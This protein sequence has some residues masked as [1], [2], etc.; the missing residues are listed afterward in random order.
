MFNIQ[1]ST[2]YVQC[3]HPDAES[4]HFVAAPPPSYKYRTDAMSVADVRRIV[5]AF[6]CWVRE[7]NRAELDAGLPTNP[8][9]PDGDFIGLG[10]PR[11]A[12]GWID[13]VTG[14]WCHIR[15]DGW[16]CYLPYGVLGHPQRQPI[17]FDKV[18][19]AAWL[20]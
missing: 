19:W 18:V 4:R 11:S 17:D 20:L 8:K 15:V 13:Y 6:N 14:R 12:L 5:S 2:P 7:W 3:E 1:S 9:S 16:R 10:H